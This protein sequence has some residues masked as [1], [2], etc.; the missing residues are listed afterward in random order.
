MGPLRVPDL[1]TEVEDGQ[2]NRRQEN[3]GSALPEV[4]RDG[5]VQFPATAAVGVRHLQEL[6]GP[7][8]RRLHG[9]QRRGDAWQGDLLR[10]QGGGRGR[11]QEKVRQ[12]LILY[13]ALFRS[14]ALRKRLCSCRRE[15]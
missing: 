15:V 1:G 7:V 10:A 4:Q 11:R 14:G 6:R 8:A 12:G 5:A 9:W 13:R 2:R 3:G